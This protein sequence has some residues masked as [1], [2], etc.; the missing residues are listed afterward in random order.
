MKIF[1]I[2]FILLAL[3]VFPAYMQDDATHQPIV[4]PNTET[5]TLTSTNTGFDYLISV[6]LPNNYSTS[7]QS[8]PVLYVLDPDISFL[9]V[10]EFVRFLAG[11]GQL[12]ELIIVGIGYPDPDQVVQLRSLDYYSSP[13][14]FLAFM[15]EELFPLIE[16]TYRADPADRGL[17]GFSYGGEFVFH[18][19]VWRSDLFNRYMAIDASGAEMMP[20]VMRNDE[21]FI[22]GFAGRDVRLFLSV[23]GTEMLSAALQAKGYEGL[24]VSGLS[25][26]SATHE[27]A[28]HLSLPAG[29][30]DIYCGVDRSIC[31]STIAQGM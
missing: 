19:L 23:E 15:S 3:Y 18:T 1:V 12:P 22:N 10:S 17:I 11:A 28:L 13:D 14:N 4:V 2:L 21:N 5:L 24:T 9:S 29:I 7:D 6:A 27:Q 20:Y 30:L 26:G 16:S 25:L 31:G 8:Y